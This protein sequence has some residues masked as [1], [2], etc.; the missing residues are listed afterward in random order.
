M[1]RTPTACLRLKMCC[2]SPVSCGRASNC[3]ISTDLILRSAF[4]RVSQDGR[5]LGRAWLPSF[6]TRASKSSVADFDT[7][8]GCRS[9]AGPTSVR[10]P[11]DEVGDVRS[12]SPEHQP[13]GTR[14]I[15]DA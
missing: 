10:A 5:L 13:A 1:R 12:P 7:L 14:E 2:G 8:F 6:E 4:R 3:F 15:D 9:R 11:Q